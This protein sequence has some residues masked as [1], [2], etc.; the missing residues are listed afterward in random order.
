MRRVLRQPKELII[1][2]L[3]TAAMLVVVSNGVSP[4]VSSAA[5]SAVTSTIT[6]AC[7]NTFNGTKF[8]LEYR[9]VGTPS[10]S[11]LPASGEFTVEWDV[12]GIASAGFLNGVYAALAAPIEVPITV[13]KLTIAPLSGV[14]GAAV[15]AGFGPPDEGFTI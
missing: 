9:I 1:V 6:A 2:T 7:N 4:G 11:P 12:T 8:P 13:D 3:M 15:Q 5:S 14:S 10:V